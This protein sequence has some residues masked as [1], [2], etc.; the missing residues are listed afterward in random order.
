MNI[1]AKAIHAEF[2][3][4]VVAVASAGIALS[5]SDTEPIIAAPFFFG[6]FLLFVEGSAWIHTAFKCPNCG[7]S[8]AT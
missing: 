1:R 5:I 7:T 6:A 8:F 3:A 4:G 2:L